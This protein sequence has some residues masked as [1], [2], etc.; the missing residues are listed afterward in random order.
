MTY[1]YCPDPECGCHDLVIKATVQAGVH[2]SPN[3][4]DA[5]VE[6]CPVDGVDWD[7]DADTYCAECG[8]R[9]PLHRFQHDEPFGSRE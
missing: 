2:F 9:G 8:Y 4:G 7:P 6:Q 5:T 1:T 3:S